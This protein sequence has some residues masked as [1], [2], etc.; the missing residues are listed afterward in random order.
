MNTVAKDRLLIFTEGE[1]SDFHIA[2]VC[3]AVKDFDVGDVRN[4]YLLAYP[5]QK[6]EYEFSEYQFIAWLVSAG[7]VKDTSCTE[8]HVGSY[9]EFKPYQ[10][11][12][13]R[14]VD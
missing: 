11:N 7:Y 6:K 8:F 9:G 13:E 12:I 2:A 5:D 3:T 4:L 14:N 1:Y 10:S